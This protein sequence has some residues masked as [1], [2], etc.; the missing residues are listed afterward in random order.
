VSLSE[1]PLGTSLAPASLVRP[2]RL[3]HVVD[4]LEIA[5]M[6]YGVIKVVNALDRARFAP[7]ICCLRAA[8]PE[9]RALLE[10]DVRVHEL[11]RSPGRNYR[12]VP[13]LASLLRAES[14]D[15]VHSHN[16]ATFLYTALS[17]RLAGTPWRIHGEHGRE[18][19][20]PPAGLRRRLAERWLA[21]S[22]H[23]MTAVSRH[24]AEDLVDRWGV[25]RNR[26]TYVP[27]GV[28]LAR[29]GTE[30]RRG[31]LRRELGLPEG[32]A[33]LGSIG[34]FRPVKDYSTLVSAFAAV[35]TQAPGTV[36][37][38]V[39]AADAE[40]ARGLERLRAELRLPG[41][42]VLLLERRHDIPAF[43]SELDVYVNSSIYEG[44]SNTILEAMACRLPVVATSVGGNP[45]LVED[46]VNGWLAPPR[47]P[48]ALADRILRLLRD[49]ARAA[50]MGA[51][52]RRRIE[53]RH[54]YAAM[55]GTYAT[56]YEAGSA[57]AA[58]RRAAHPVRV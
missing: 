36:L 13:R 49:P 11:H 44:M 26:V 19:E 42:S 40:S 14:V 7:G 34:R 41:G 9:A 47:D 52:G 17:S 10:P 29:F 12:L 45:D 27:N 48:A 35:R 38:I 53:E 22:F 33:V 39:G 18:T 20:A 21:G 56:L 24:I 2:I 32:A 50:A 3:L 28:D 25:S 37:V 51:A 1:A 30:P 57:L 8:S 46:G 58:E 15:V 4:R 43:L 5:G 54:S 23:H 55:I 31:A 16:W 6:E